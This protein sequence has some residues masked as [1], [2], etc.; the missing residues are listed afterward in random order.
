[1]RGP[2]DQHRGATARTKDRRAA[3]ARKADRPR[4]APRARSAQTRRCSSTS[5]GS[6]PPPITR[7]APAR[8]AATPWRWWIRIAGA[9]DQRPA[10]RRRLD[11]A[12]HG[13]LQHQRALVF[14]RRALRRFPA[15]GSR[16][17][18]TPETLAPRGSDGIARG[19]RAAIRSEGIALADRRRQNLVSWC[20]SSE[21]CLVMLELVPGIQQ[22]ADA[23]ADGWVD[24]GNTD[25]RR[26]RQAPE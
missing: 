1:M 9:W 12:D 22:S 26:C 16:C 8:W 19:Q 23:R 18:L 3:G 7:S 14:G 5:P 10:R 4:G 25:L 21:H 17:Q 2:Q 20:E 6:G 24:P 13:V 11:H 15:A